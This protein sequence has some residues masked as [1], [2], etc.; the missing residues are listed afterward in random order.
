LPRGG[1]GAP[2]DDEGGQQDP[3][4]IA[5]EIRRATAQAT[6]A[7]V[8]DAL[9]SVGAAD[10]GATNGLYDRRG[11]LP[12]FAQAHLLHAMARAK[13]PAAQLA[14]FAKE[15][16]A[17]LQIGAGS[18]RAEPEGA[19]W[20]P[21]LDSGT[22][23]TALVLRALLAV[24]PRHPLAPRLVRGLLDARENGAWR[25][26][27]ENVWSLIA[28]DAYRRAQEPKPKAPLDARI[29][30]GGDELGRPRLTG[31]EEARFFVPA[32][33]LKK[34]GGPLAFALE[35]TGKLFYAAELR[36]TTSALPTRPLD[37]GLFVQRLVRSVRPT[38]LQ[39]ALESLPKQSTTRVR[40]GELVLVDL[41][42]ETGEPRDQIVI[43]D[44]LPSGVE[45]I[46]VNLETVAASQAIVDGPF[47]RYG[48]K[49]S[50]SALSARAFGTA[51]VHREHHDDRVLTFL[52]HVEPG[53]Y[54][55][56]YLGRA[57]AAGTYVLPPARAEAMYA[58]E[59]QGRTAATT[60]AVTR[61]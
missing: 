17:R 23:S 1:D 9:A 7:I 34:S 42:F 27:Q 22:R 3:W 60:L 44:P 50:A 47:R 53:I 26:T 18:A 61:E 45:P 51:T 54:H 4:G 58:P 39:K 24:D 32:E 52:G 48:E 8:L 10:P 20:S 12:I 29:F 28:L 30:L 40:L 56:R 14:I 35:G 13:L 49:P 38:D 46:D 41:L 6:G 5:P 25:S 36:T 21:M 19:L 16:E 59:I 31:L 57:T 37:R 2:D 11:E 15:I 43:D 55:F 33:R